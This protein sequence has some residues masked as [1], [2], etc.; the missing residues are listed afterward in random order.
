MGEIRQCRIFKNRDNAV[1]ALEGSV[2]TVV[3]CGTS[4]TQASFIIT[5]YVFGHLQICITTALQP[6]TRSRAP[7][8]Q[9][10]SARSVRTNVGYA[11]QVTFCRMNPLAEFVAALCLRSRRVACTEQRCALLRGGSL[12]LVQ[13]SWTIELALRS[14]WRAS[15]ETCKEVRRTCYLFCA[16]RSL[17]S[18]YFH[19]RHDTTVSHARLAH[20]TTRHRPCPR[21]ILDPICS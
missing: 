2:L 11:A 1:H 4:V 8:Q 20:R 6:W 21:Y 16:R 3:A 19:C 9:C 14:V 15:W 10:S 5:A 7:R 12:T 18:P 17:V 13:K